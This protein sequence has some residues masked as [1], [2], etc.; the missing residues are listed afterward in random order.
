[1]VC[2]GGALYAESL[3]GSFH[4]DFHPQSNYNMCNVFVSA[5]TASSAQYLHVEMSTLDNIELFATTTTIPTGKRKSL[6]ILNFSLSH[7]ASRVF[8][9]IAVA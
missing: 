3:Q 7:S 6:S 9:A 5:R 4:Y 1:M 8:Q 2:V